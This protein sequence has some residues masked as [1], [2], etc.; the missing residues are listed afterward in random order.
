MARPLA[1]ERR[2]AAAGGMAQRFRRPARVWA[3]DAVERAQVARDPPQ[4]GAAEEARAE[5]P[6]RRR[7]V[8]AP[9]R[10]PRARLR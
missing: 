5:R 2:A 3:A 6:L 10:T 1:E 4:D 7:V 8:P 9:G